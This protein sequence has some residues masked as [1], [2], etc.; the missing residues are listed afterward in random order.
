MYLHIYIYIFISLKPFICHWVIVHGQ[1][2]ILYIYV[3]SLKNGT[4]TDV[5][6]EPACFM[7]FWVVMILLSIHCFPILL[8][9]L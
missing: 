9:I 6:T 7:V 1:F 8:L 5:H 4:G 3:F 2:S